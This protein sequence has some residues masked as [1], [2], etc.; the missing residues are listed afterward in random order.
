MDPLVTGFEEFELE[1]ALEFRM[2]LERRETQ[3]DRMVAKSKQQ[4]LILDARFCP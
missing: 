2:P 1:A 3:G 4:Q